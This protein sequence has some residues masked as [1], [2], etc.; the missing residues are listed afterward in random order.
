MPERDRFAADDAGTYSPDKYY[1]GIDSGGFYERVR[2]V[3]LAPWLYFALKTACAEIPAYKGRVNYFVRDAIR[4]RME[5][6]LPKIEDPKKR[7]KLQREFQLA[8]LQAE[9]EDLL[10]HGAEQQSHVQRC[11]AVFK[12]LVEAKSY[13]QLGSHLDRA[14]QSLSQMWDPYATQLKLLVRQY[15]KVLREAKT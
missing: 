12:V 5:Y 11:E 6:V 13:I 15:R 1:V 3:R 7:E 14:E 9:Q 4:H 2:D 10:A 8:A